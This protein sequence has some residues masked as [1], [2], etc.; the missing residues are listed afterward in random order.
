MPMKP[1]QSSEAEDFNPK[2]HIISIHSGSDPKHS[3]K[4]STTSM[5][6]DKTASEKVHLNERCRCTCPPFDVPNVAR[7]SGQIYTG[8][9]DKSQDCGCR[10]IVLPS[11]PGLKPENYKIVDEHVCPT[12]KCVYQRRNLAIIH[13]VVVFIVVL[14][15]GF[16]GYLCISHLIWPKLFAVSLSYKEHK[17]DDDEMAMEEVNDSNPQVPVQD[18]GEEAS[19]NNSKLRRIPLFSQISQSQ[20]KWHQ[21]LHQQQRNIYEDHSM[22]N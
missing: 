16:T 1:I 14:V 8:Q 18:H 12:C 13:I 7:M 4:E 22:L 9:V 17:D 19:H 5:S 20:T 15:T 6:S 2:D 11:I 21:D 10:N 3:N